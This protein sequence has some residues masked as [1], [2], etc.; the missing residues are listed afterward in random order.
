MLKEQNPE[1]TIRDDS[2]CNIDLLNSFIDKPITDDLRRIAQ[3]TKAQSVCSNMSGTCCTDHEFNY[4]H[5]NAAQNIQRISQIVHFQSQTVEDLASLSD[6]DFEAI[7]T[8]IDY[9]TVSAQF[10][11]EELKQSMLELR[12]NADKYKDRASRALDFIL[13]SGSGIVCGVCAP[14][15]Q[16][17]LYLAHEQDDHE[18]YQVEWSAD[19]CLSI[20]Q[21]EDIGAYSDFLNDTIEINRLA[22]LL[23]QK[24][25]MNVDFFMAYVTKNYEGKF[26]DFEDDPCRDNQYFF[27]NFDECTDQCTELGVMNQSPLTFILEV[28]GQN[29]LFLHDYAHERRFLQ[30]TSANASNRSQKIEID[31]AR[32]TN[33]E[34]L[35]RSK[36]NQSEALRRSMQEAL[37]GIMDDIRLYTYLTQTPNAKINMGEA[38]VTYVTE[39]GWESRVFGSELFIE[40][41]ERRSESRIEEESSS[42]SSRSV[43]DED[44]TSEIIR[45]KSKSKRKSESVQSETRS[46]DKSVSKSK[47]QSD[48]KSQTKSEIKSRTKSVVLV[49]MFWMFAFVVLLRLK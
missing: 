28:F 2:D 9:E 27:E 49:E 30:D 44:Q 36:T 48:V 18:G 35:L 33:N 19:E 12:E 1:Y 15:N 43:I 46:E 32:K 5:Q 25:K 47:T 31:S 26:F 4:L 8:G 14:E 13:R 21:D 22:Y 39:T 3:L 16:N 37:D 24:F 40:E 20:L 11:I 41:L 17:F 23:N 34:E 29:Y 38:K 6:L 10:D 7:F 42:N 45:E